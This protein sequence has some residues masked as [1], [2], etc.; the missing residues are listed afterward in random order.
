META[1]GA[2]AARA[3]NARSGG[4]WSTGASPSTVTTII[5]LLPDDDVDA[6][7]LREMPK[8]CDAA[9]TGS[10]NTGDGDEAVRIDE[11]GD[12]ARACRAACGSRRRSSRESGRRPRDGPARVLRVG[13][14]RAGLADLPARRRERPGRAHHLAIDL[15]ADRDLGERELLD[16][17]VALVRDPRLDAGGPVRGVEP[18]LVSVAQAVL[19]LE[20]PGLRFDARDA[21]DAP[22]MR[23]S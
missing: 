17:L 3:R 22:A 16:G 19:G 2:S 6:A 5:V 7:L 15:A 12:A 10:T 23:N 14:A 18:E 11:M 4:S 21:I 13:L 8:G 20:H 9:P 1:R